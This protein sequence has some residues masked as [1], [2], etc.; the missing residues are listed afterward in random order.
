MGLPS[1]GSPIVFYTVVQS[2]D[3]API[4]TELIALKAKAGLTSHILST[5]IIPYKG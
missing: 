1:L 4:P 3:T 2:P 5:K